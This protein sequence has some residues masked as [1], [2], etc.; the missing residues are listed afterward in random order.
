MAFSTGESD[1]VALRQTV[2]HPN[3]HG[4]DAGKAEKWVVSD[5]GTGF[6]IVMAPTARDA[7]IRARELLKAAPNALEKVMAVPP[8]LT[9]LTRDEFIAKYEFDPLLGRPVKTK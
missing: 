9:L 7:E 2:I 6:N 3:L 1:I 8:V 4:A 5:V